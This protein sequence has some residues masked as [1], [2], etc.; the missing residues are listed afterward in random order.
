MVQALASLIERARP[1]LV[2]VTGD[3]THRNKPH[4][5]DAAAEFLRAFGTELLVVPGNHDIPLWPPWRFTST[6]SA[7]E[8]T[9]GTAQPIYRSERLFVVGL[10]SV[11]PWRQQS[12][13]LR[14]RQ[15]EWAAEQLRTAPPNA[16]RLVALHHHMIGAPWR[17][18]K[19]P[20]AERNRVLGT[21]V[22]CGA[23]LILAGHTHQ[24]AVSERR[25]FEVVHGD[26]GAVVVSI[27]PG[28]GQP[29]PHRRGEARGLHVYG[30]ADSTIGIS[31]YIWRDDD[32]ALTAERVFPRG[33]RPLQ[34]ER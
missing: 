11:R 32:W 15:L 13:G 34:V 5:H 3:L 12:G 20:V 14:R 9:W 27:A 17:T 2:V 28:L 18:R 24:A 6:F 16:L 1:E 7:F 23:E 26:V 8:R 31:T 22:D 19:R 10:N 30:V 25:E 4:Q 33:M 21:L 29:R